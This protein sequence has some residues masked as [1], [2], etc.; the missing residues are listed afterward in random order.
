[1]DKNNIGVDRKWYKFWIDEWSMRWG[2]DRFLLVTWKI[3]W[4]ICRTVPWKQTNRVNTIAP[5][6]HRSVYRC[7]WFQPWQSETPRE[8]EGWGSVGETG[9]VRGCQ[10]EGVLGV[11]STVTVRDSPGAGWSEK[12]R[13]IRREWISNMRW[14]GV[15]MYTKRDH[16][17]KRNKRRTH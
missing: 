2:I 6:R 3:L 13:W 1:M 8:L 7:L 16:K 10:C 4:V 14:K 12:W 15:N 5:L 9:L 17:R 11:I